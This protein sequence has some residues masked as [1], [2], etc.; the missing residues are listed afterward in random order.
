MKKAH[1]LTI[2]AALIMTSAGYTA[3]AESHATETDDMMMEV[4]M[5]QAGAEKV[6]KSNGAATGVLA[7]TAKGDMEFDAAAVEEAKQTLIMNAQSI[8]LIFVDQFDGEE[9]L[10]AIWENYDDFTVKAKALEDAA[11][12]L[13]VSSA[14][15][16]GA[17]LGAIGGACGACHQAY[18][19]KS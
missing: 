10:P 2:A 5:G 14:E 13:D 18:R 9:T 19:A 16:I 1:I 17:G 11:A 12:A 8:P 7:K 4:M 6:M 15:T 3:L